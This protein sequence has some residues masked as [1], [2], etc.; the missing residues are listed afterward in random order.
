MPSWNEIEKEIIEELSRNT[1]SIDIIDRKRKEYIEHLSEL[2]GRNTIVYYSDFLNNKIN[3]HDELSI[4]NK[5]TIGFMTTIY[6]LD[7]TKGLDLILHTPG[8][9]IAATES[10]VH[11]LKDMFDNNIRT[12]IPQL[13]MSAGTMITMAS[14]EIIMG[15][16]S[17]VGPFDPQIGTV[18]VEGI[19]EEFEKVKQ[20]IKRNQNLIH[21]WGHILNK[22]TPTLLGECE[23]VSAW[24]KNLIRDWLKSNMFKDDN[25]A[26]D[27][28][29]DIIKLLGSHKATYSHNRQ[30]SASTLTKTCKL[31]ITMLEND[32]KLQDAVLSI[33]HIC[34]M[35][36]SN[37]QVY[38]I[39][40]NNIGEVL[41]AAVNLPNNRE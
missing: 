25:E 16:H 19:L 13:A 35:T 17:S 3:N 26:K 33:H 27:K 20:D 10:L 34:M 24:S 41:T 28:I 8:G 31:N 1:K 21:I 2:T 12:I 23:K 14:K 38:K 37:S 40:E 39:I 15:K 9:D 6:K 29:E 32:P 30:Y 5:D 22:Y 36:F 11:Y 18:S 4:N 7:R